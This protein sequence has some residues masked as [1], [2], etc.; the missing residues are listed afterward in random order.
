MKVLPWMKSLCRTEDFYAR[1]TKSH[2][3]RGGGRSPVYNLFCIDCKIKVCSCCQSPHEGHT[4]LQVRAT[5]FLSARPP[6]P[7]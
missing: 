6:F 1:C 2:D 7:V 3:Q 5:L 4:L